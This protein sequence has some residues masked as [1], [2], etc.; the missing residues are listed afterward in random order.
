MKTVDSLLHNANIYIVDPL[1]YLLFGLALIYF[2]WGVL[3]FIMSADNDEARNT[4]KRHMIWGIIGM[5]IMISAWGIIGIIT[6]TF[7]ISNQDSG[8]QDIKRQ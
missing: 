1:I 2:L 6:G 5:F 4:G 8:I 3:Q 7:H